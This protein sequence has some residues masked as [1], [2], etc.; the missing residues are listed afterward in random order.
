MNLRRFKLQ[1]ALFLDKPI[2]KTSRVKEILKKSTKN[3]KNSARHKIKSTHSVSADLE[4]NLC[5]VKTECNEKID[6]PK[7]PKLS[8]ISRCSFIK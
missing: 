5:E 4:V 8:S 7:E 6:Q 3:K 2:R 1:N